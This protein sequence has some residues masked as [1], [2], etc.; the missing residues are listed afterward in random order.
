MTVTSKIVA[1][2]LAVLIVTATPVAT[3]LFAEESTRLNYVVAKTG[4]Y[5]PTGDLDSFDT[6]LNIEGAFGRYFHKNFLIEGG[7]GLF[8]TEDDIQ[9]TS[10]ILGTYTETDT[11]TAV[12]LTITAKGILPLDKLELFAGAGVGIY[13]TEV[14]AEL[15]TSALG[16]FNVNDADIVMG[17]HVT[18]GGIYNFNERFFFGIDGKYF[19][20]EKAEYDGVILG[21]SITLKGDLTGYTVN[22]FFGYRF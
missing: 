1:A 22:G 12:P 4:I 14:D 18:G 21:R 6:G 10:A 5:N 7:V 2:I 17:V 20:T 8:G 9:G 11:I 13:F 16:T 15:N 3:Q 19:S